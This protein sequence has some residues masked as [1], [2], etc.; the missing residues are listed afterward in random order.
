MANDAKDF[1][2]DKGYDAAYGARPLKRAI[3]KYLEDPLAE[4]IIQSKIK[5]GDTIKVELDKV[6]K[7]LVMTVV[8][9]KP[10]KA[11]TSSEKDA[12]K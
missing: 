5:E 6:T 4:E 11:D 3:Q 10:K 12:E 1:I 9:E 8:K 7:E 2:A